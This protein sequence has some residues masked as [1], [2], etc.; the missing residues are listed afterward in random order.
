MD[1]ETVAT[2]AGAEQPAELEQLLKSDR[3]TLVITTASEAA[4]LEKMG[5]SLIEKDAAYALFEKK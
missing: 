3:Q 2:V 5:L 1:A 4:G